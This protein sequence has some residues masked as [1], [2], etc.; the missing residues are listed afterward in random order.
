[1]LI[2]LKI[3]FSL[4]L[5]LFIIKMVWSWNHFGIKDLDVTSTLISD[6]LEGKEPHLTTPPMT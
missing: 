6:V 5:F 2:F 1:M 4:S 3:F